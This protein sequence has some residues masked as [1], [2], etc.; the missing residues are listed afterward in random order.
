MQRIGKDNQLLNLDKLID[1]KA[2]ENL[3]THIHK[4]DVDS[5]GG[6][7]RYKHLSMFKAILLGRWHSLSDPALE[8]ALRVRLDFILF[9]GLES[10]EEVPD[11]TTLCRFRNVL[12][13]KGLDRV[14]FEAINKQLES[15]GLKV[16]K[17]SAAVIDATIIQSACRPKTILEPLPEDPQRAA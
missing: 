17:A 9:T 11:E 7:I 10:P 3:L 4:N 15:L 5:R 2:I 12:I 16:E 1:W 14:L 13:K 8:D 6:P